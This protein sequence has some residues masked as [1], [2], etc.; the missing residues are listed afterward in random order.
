MPVVNRV[1]C[2]GSATQIGI[3]H[4]GLGAFHRAHQAVYLQR[5]LNRHGASDWGLCSANLRSNRTLVEQLREQDGRYH[6]AEYRDREQVTLR[7]IGVLREALYAGEGGHELEQLLE[8]MAAPQT[9][10][11]TL[12]VTEKGYCLSPS[13]GQLRR[14][15]PTIAHDIAHPHTPRSAPGIVLEALRRRRAA[16][17]AAFTVLCCDNMPDNGQRTRQAVGAL[18]ALQDPALAQWVEQQVAFPSCMVDRIVPA[19]DEES[20]RRLE[21]LDCH[22]RAAVVS[23]S[24]SQWVVE[25]H[26]P[27]G[28]PDWEVEGVQMVDDV[29]PFETM[30]LRMLNGSHSLLAYVGLLAGHESVFEAVNDGRLARLIERYMTE[31][32]VPTLHMPAGIDLMKYAEDLRT[33]FAN[34]SLQHRLRQIAMDGSQKLPQRW[35][36]GAQQLLDQGRGIDCTALGIA[37]WIHYCTQPLPG[38]A[39]H[40]VDDPLSATF[41]DLAGRFDGASR[42]DAFLGLD[43]IFPPALSARPAFRDAVHRA[44]SALARDG[45]GNLLQTVATPH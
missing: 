45:V 21:Q 24:F 9:R 43:E 37:A 13:S 38:R 44:Y 14:D 35:L 16:G 19:M 1:P 23:E 15:D 17:I 25:D 27:L 22:D 30:K 12:T 32:A 8:R 34:D 33:R 29:R 7:E 26:F 28:R 5:H 3:V 41:A 31:E 10:I 18:A 36:L 42:V 40:V 39:A 11:V 20:F 2:T 4:L 6:V